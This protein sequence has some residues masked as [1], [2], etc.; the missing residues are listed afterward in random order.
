MS[1]IER[2]DLV[3]TSERRCAHIVR[4]TG[5]L[6]LKVEAFCGRHWPYSWCRKITLEGVSWAVCKTCERAFGEGEW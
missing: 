4:R 2:G 1:Q 6:Q 3:E 5:E